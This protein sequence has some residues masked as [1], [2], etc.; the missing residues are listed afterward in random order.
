MKL[1][2]FTNSGHLKGMP[3]Y[4]NADHITALFETPSVDGGTLQTRLY[5]G[6]TGVE[7]IIEEGLSEALALIRKK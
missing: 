7:W 1:I 6:P 5:G 4:I 3:L 2:K